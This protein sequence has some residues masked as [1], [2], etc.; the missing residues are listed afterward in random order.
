[1]KSIIENFLDTETDEELKE[2]ARN[3]VIGEISR[4][5]EFA[6]FKRKIV[7]DDVELRGEFDKQLEIGYTGVKD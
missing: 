6:A 7:R 3:K 2:I 1:M 4:A 5:S